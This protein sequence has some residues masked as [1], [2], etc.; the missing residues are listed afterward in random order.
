VEPTTTDG[1]WEPGLGPLAGVKVIDM[2]HALAGPFATM[3]LGDLGATVYKIERPGQGDHARQMPPVIEGMGIGFAASNR[4]KR[5]V[6][7]DASQPEGRALLLSLG[8]RADAFVHN[9]RPGV[10]EQL[11]LDAAALRAVNPHIVFTA[12]SGFGQDGPW[13]R[14]PAFDPTIQALAGVSAIT[15]SPG[16]PAPAGIAIADLVSPLYAVIGVIAGLYEA[17]GGNGGRSMDVSMFDALFNLHAH[18]IAIYNATG[19]VPAPSGERRSE[20]FPMGTFVTADGFIVIAALNERF[21]LNLCAALDRPEWNDADR[22]GSVRARSKKRDE[23]F[24]ELRRILAERTTAEW[25]D[26]LMA[27]DVPCGAVTDYPAL[28]DSELV[29]ERRL[30]APVTIESPDGGSRQV[31]VPARPLKWSD[32]SM[33]IRLRPP[34]LG[35]HTREVLEGELGLEPSEVDRLAEQQIVGLPS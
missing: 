25:T 7:I 13:S 20:A 29:S 34:R 26:L 8:G 33:D 5:S 2:T 14:R 15:G 24:D 16:A 4:N 19:K 6:A 11:G 27:H 12:I 28:M 31:E 1:Q 9:F 35:E 32:F 3:L 17:R 30:L 23:L 21:W 10:M 22:F 18:R